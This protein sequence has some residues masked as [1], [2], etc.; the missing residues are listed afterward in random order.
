MEQSLIIIGAESHIFSLN[1]R[2]ELCVDVG[3]RDGLR[4]LLRHGRFA[5]VQTGDAL[6]EGTKRVQHLAGV[7]VAGALD[8][9]R[10]R[11]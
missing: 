5:Q 9:D 2:H 3:R 10:I 6:H 4:L 1:G 7:K 8:A 11:T